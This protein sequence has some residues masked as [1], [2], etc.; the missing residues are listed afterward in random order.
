MRRIPRDVSIQLFRRTPEGP[1]FL[2]LRRCPERGG[3]WQPVTGAP[4]PEE[5]DA[6]AAV[7]EVHEETGFTCLTG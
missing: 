7:R 6:D 4:L 3:F 1:R 5:N 2:M